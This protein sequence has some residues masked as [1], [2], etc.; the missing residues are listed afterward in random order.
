LGLSTVG[1][2]GSESR[3]GS[4]R[5]RCRAVPEEQTRLGVVKKKMVFFRRLVL[6]FG[7]HYFENGS[8]RPFC[9]GWPPKNVLWGR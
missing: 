9:A 5:H 6:T 7:R 4:N 1:A 2:I 3:M 8:P